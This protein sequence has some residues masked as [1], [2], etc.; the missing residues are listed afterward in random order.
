MQIQ[1]L[2]VDLDQQGNIIQELELQRAEF[3][4]MYEDQAQQIDKITEQISSQ[5]KANEQ[6]VRIVVEQQAPAPRQARQE[7]QTAENTSIKT[8]KDA[9]GKITTCKVGKFTVP[10]RGNSAAGCD[11]S[12]GIMDRQCGHMVKVD[13]FLV[14]AQFRMLAL[15]KL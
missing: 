4:R 13:Q 7:R 8:V 10:V 6:V 12:I 9:L 3:K 14:V 1:K 15:S 11:C 2:A 5:Q